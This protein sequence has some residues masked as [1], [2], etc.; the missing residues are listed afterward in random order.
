MN[1][2]SEERRDPTPSAGARPTLSEDRYRRGTRRTAGEPLAASWEPVAGG[3]GHRK[4]RRGVKG[5]VGNYGWRIYALPVLLVLTVLVVLDSTAPGGAN[6][7][8]Q[9]PLA[10]DGPAA[11]SSQ[12]ELPTVNETPPSNADLVDI[13]TAVLPDGPKFSEQGTG[14]WQV[15]P[16]STNP[17]GSGVLVEYAIAI[18]DGIDPQDYNGDRDAFARTIDGFLSDV[19]SWVGTGQVA[20]RRVDDAGRADFVISLTSTNTTHQLC[21]FQIQ[22]E[23]SCWDRTTKRVVINTAR[24]VRGA[25]A[26]SNDLSSYRQ[27]A[28]NHEVGHAIGKGHEGCRGNG[29][30]APVMMQQTFGVANDYVARLNE[31]DASNRGVV[32]ADG[33]VCTANAFPVAPK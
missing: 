27:Y 15:V 23:S 21:G 32:A 5:L 33:K 22:Y 29:Q 30:P 19:R 26:F 31:V 25:K 24:W 20:M 7:G 18:E 3:V 1:R 16:G 14:T 2:T 11:S 28:I 4:R 10:Q 17:V 8:G 13:P 9:S 6:G 12:P